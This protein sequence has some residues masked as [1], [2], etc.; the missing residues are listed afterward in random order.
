MTTAKITYTPSEWDP[1]DPR[2]ARCE[3]C[4]EESDGRVLF[5]Y[6]D[7]HIW[8]CLACWDL[9]RRSRSHPYSKAMDKAAKLTNGYYI[10]RK[11]A[12]M[13]WPV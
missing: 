5:E 7:G 1:V 4:D 9:L 10:N 6:Y 13:R 8:V 11:F 2:R 3:F 12:S